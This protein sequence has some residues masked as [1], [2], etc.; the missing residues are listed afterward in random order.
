[1]TTYSVSEHTTIR[2]ELT[3]CGN[4]SR[5]GQKAEQN[6][7]VSV[8]EVLDTTKEIHGL[9]VSSFRDIPLKIDRNLAG[10]AWYC[11]VSKKLFDEIKKNG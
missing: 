3:G 1:M 9:L 6:K 4:Q 5:Q 8:D 11:A 7:A 2:D 10:N